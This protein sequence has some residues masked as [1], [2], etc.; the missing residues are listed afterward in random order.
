MYTVYVLHEKN[1]LQNSMCEMTKLY[2][3]SVNILP[4]MQKKICRLAIVQVENTRQS[5]QLQ[6]LWRKPSV[7]QVYPGAPSSVEVDQGPGLPWWLSSK[8]SACNAG[9]PGLIPGSGRS[10]TGGHGRQPNPVFLPGK[11]CEERSL[12]GYSPWGHKIVR[13]D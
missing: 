3:K 1:S 13:H 11:S 7:W 12:A 10:P 6:G 8:E 9:D 2:K 5:S 4:A